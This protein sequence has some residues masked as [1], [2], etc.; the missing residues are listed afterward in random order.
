[1]LSLH[2]CRVSALLLA[3]TLFAP[4][5]VSVAEAEVASGF[6]PFAGVGVGDPENEASQAA[7]SEEP[8]IVFTADEVSYDQASGLVRAIGNVE[9]TYG[10]RILLASQVTYDERRDVVLA[11][12]DIALVEPTGEVVFANRIEL[13]GDLKS[14]IIEDF[15]VLL[16]DGSRIAANGGRRTGGNFTEMSKGVYSPCDLCED[17]P[18]SPPLWQLKAVRIFHDQEKKRIEYS[19]A[20]LEVAG[21]PVFY[22]PFLSHPDPTVKRK[23]GLLVPGFGNSSDFGFVFSIPFYW[24]ISE[25]RDATI[26]PI[27][28]TREGVVLAVDYRQAMEN[29]VLNIETSATND[30]NDDFRGAIL[31]E[32]RYDFDDTWRG[33]I[34]FE[35]STDETYL[36]RYGF[37]SEQSLTSRA[38]VEGFRGRNYLVANGY[39]FQR[40]QESFPGQEDNP[41]VLP[42]INYNYVGEADRIGGRLAVD[43]D[44]S[45]VNRQ[46]G[47]EYQ[48]ASIRSD[49]SLA[50]R[51]GVGGIY[52]ASA[53]LWADGYHVGD[54]TIVGQPGSFS[55]V[56]GRV[57]PQAALEW[58]FPIARSG[59]AYD[60]ILAPIVEVIAAPNGGNPQE[61]PNEDSRDFELSANNLFGIDR[62]P[63]LDRVEAGSRASY[64][65]EWQMFR[66][67]GGSIR[68]VVGNTYRFAVDSDLRSDS[69]I[70]GHLGDI[71]GDIRFQ[72][73][74]WLSL[75]Y[76]MSLDNKALSFNRNEVT[77]GAGPSLFRVLGSYLLLGARSDPVI[78]E[79]EELRLTAVSQFSRY[80]QFRAFG[81]H[82]LTIDQTLAIGAGVA[83]EDECLRL[84]VSY[85]REEF[86]DRDLQP[87]DAVFIRLS[88]K[89]LG[90]LE[91]G[92]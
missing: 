27:I 21:I 63:G 91:F 41:V 52:T 25:H 46:S 9:A 81:V 57:F 13:A 56:T 23:S 7:E 44:F 6:D 55:G 54:N 88:L 16:S 47:T 35:R 67:A 64:G 66:H 69:G 49:Y 80:W 60:H 58:R 84:D 83:Y 31:S 15:R 32:L 14:G 77:F 17:D 30:G 72:F 65:L 73:P 34:D 90:D 61:I 76:R 42:L 19:D 70:E 3:A 85:Q 50:M 10:D 4:G 1:M 87:R 2:R 71:V 8:A 75:D 12:G 92:L 79:R 40:L 82:D 33:G 89:T 24:A 74:P 38:F 29:G 51:D 22:S 68:A 59:E 62:L 28:T 5:S 53:A 37:S 26:T 39:A 48:R 45:A 78:E 11:E 43:V 36:R 86:E 18:E 20:W